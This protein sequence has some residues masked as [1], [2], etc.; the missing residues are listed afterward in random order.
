MRATKRQQIVLFPHWGGNDQH[1]T[2]D[3]LV[4]RRSAAISA[5]RRELLE[6]L[7][8]VEEGARWL[9]A[10]IVH[11]YDKPVRHIELACRDL[12]EITTA[13]N[14]LKAHIAAGERVGAMPGRL[15][16]E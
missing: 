4:V 7:R 13:L 1:A 14:S 16:K 2:V 15:I 5:P 12:E 8:R 9:A 6:L 10:T 3:W 11:C